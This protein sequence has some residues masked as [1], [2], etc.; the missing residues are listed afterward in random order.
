VMDKAKDH[1]KTCQPSEVEVKDV[2]NAAHD[3]SKPSHFNPEVESISVVE[4]KISDESEMSNANNNATDESFINV[5]EEEEDDLG[6]TIK[7]DQC[8]KISEETNSIQNISVRL[9]EQKY[10]R[11]NRFASTDCS[12]LQILSEIANSREKIIAN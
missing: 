4:D 8:D 2:E 5:E 3:V 10:S 11:K 7:A 6:E 1:D 9:E 12:G